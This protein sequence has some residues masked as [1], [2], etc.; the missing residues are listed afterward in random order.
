M[1]TTPSHPGNVFRAPVALVLL[2]IGLMLVAWSEFQAG[3]EPL[4]TQ[5]VDVY[6]ELMAAHNSR[7]P[8]DLRHSHGR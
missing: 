8:P 6:A 3:Q 5:S 4:Y 2:L 1:R 7:S